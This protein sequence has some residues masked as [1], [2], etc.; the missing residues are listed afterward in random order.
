MAYGLLQ[1]DDNE[2]SDN[3]LIKMRDSNS[4]RRS[5]Q[6]KSP[7]ELSAVVFDAAHF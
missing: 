7:P 6:P 2:R 5:F 4:A 3:T 1:T